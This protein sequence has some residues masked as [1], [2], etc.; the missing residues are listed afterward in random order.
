M[1]YHTDRSDEVVALRE[2]IKQLE[3]EKLA[4]IALLTSDSPVEYPFEPL[5]PKP[6]DDCM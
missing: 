3:Q 4:L 5:S 2:R 1:N 6:P